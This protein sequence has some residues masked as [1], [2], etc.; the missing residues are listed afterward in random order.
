MFI[1][2]TGYVQSDY[3]FRAPIF[4]DSA[5]TAYYLD[6]NGTSNL[7]GLTL[8]SNV[9]TGRGSYG[10]STANLVLLASSTYGRATID[11]RS[12]VNYPSDGAQIYYETATNGVSGETSRL[13]IRTENDADDSIL[14]RGGFVEINS[15][16]VDGGSTNPGFRVLYNN[17]ARLYTYSDNTTEFGSF[18]A[19]LF[20]D[21]NDTT[22]YM[23]YASTTSGLLRGNLRFNDYGAGIVGTYDSTRYQAVFSMGNAYLL[24][25]AGTSTGNL[26]G[27]AWSHP[28]A[29]GAASNLASHGMLILENGGFQG[30]WGGGS[31]RTPGDVRGTLFYDWNNTA[32]Y[33]D[34]ASTS[35]LNALAIGGQ[36]TLVAP[37]GNGVVGTNNAIWGLVKPNGY[38]LYPDE[39]FRD[40]N[41]GINIYNN[42]GGS[43]ISITRKNSSFAD[44]H[45]GPPN[46]SGYVLEI[47]HSPATSAGTSP[48][49][50][51]WYFAT[52]TGPAAR[53]LLCVF[54]MKIPSG[55]SVQWAS[56]SIGSG[57]SG[58]WLTSQ[59]GTGQYQD[60]AFVVNSGTASWSSTFFFY[61]VGGGTSTFY[62]YLAS[63]TVY[64]VSDVSAT[65]IRTAY[66]SES[67]RA[68]V[69][70]DSN[71]T[72]SINKN[73]W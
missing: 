18:R 2:S 12:G 38:K 17:N 41:N 11:F 29:G 25:I 5:N 52:Y 55:R 1:A 56:N 36:L 34:P 27:I 53:R 60:Y 51:G 49:Y 69:F 6:P 28:N 3:S 44:G 67:M 26:Y 21:S 70:Y 71:N 33:V 15:T 50:G 7:G 39:D 42:A 65:N 23:D 72:N 19:P 59:D 35:N 64:D 32:F 62:T 66:A 37:G 16:T 63:A 45:A 22:Y 46:S 9:A 31:L 43:A 20:Y 48:G 68:P 24:P 47:N 13:V 14:I 4:Y 54:K 10:S 30:A 61:I 40:G 57:G 58:A 73:C 8:E